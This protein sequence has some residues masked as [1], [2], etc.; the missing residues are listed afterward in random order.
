[1]A[2]IRGMLTVLALGSALV[3]RPAESQAG[4]SVSLTHSVTVTVPP[5]VKVQ[6]GGAA[7]RQGAVGVSQPGVNALSV[8]VAA[9]QSWRL[10]IGAANESSDMQWSFNRDGDFRSVASREATIATGGISPVPRA[11][12]VFFRRSNAG[13]GADRSSGDETVVLTMV[14]P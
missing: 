5:R 2:A 11:S 14:A 12:T 13:G 3:A 1:M 10:S 4:A 7:V 9:T 6:L 8:S